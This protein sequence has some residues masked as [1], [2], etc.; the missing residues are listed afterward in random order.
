MTH[1][2]SARTC[3]RMTTRSCLDYGSIKIGLNTP[4][5]QQNPVD[6]LTAYLLFNCS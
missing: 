2:S 3:I 5:V 6:I 4:N 1:N